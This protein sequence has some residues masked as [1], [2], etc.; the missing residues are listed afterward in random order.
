MAPTR[1]EEMPVSW[2][3]E[4]ADRTHYRG[5]PRNIEPI[6]NIEWDKGLQPKKYEIFGT[7]TESKVLFLD[8]NILDSTGKEPFR[9]NVLI[10]GTQMS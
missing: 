4:D 8:V 7:H 1:S 5:P 6:N 10:E 9:G 2:P 3:T